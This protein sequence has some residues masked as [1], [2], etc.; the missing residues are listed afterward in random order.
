[1]ISTVSILRRFA[2]ASFEIKAARLERL[3]P[4]PQ[5]GAHARVRRLAQVIG[6][7]VETADR[8][9]HEILSRN[10]RGRRA[11]ARDAGLTGAPDESGA[12][13]REKGL[14]GPAP[15]FKPGA[16]SG[17]NRGPAMPG[18]ATGSARGLKAHMA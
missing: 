6:V 11:V 4:H 12:R 13:R 8:L 15:P 3:E 9:A 14:A 10:P 7:G 17:T 1:M 16:G 18:R 5:Q 2:A